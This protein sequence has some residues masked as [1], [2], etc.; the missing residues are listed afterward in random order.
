MKVMSPGMG[1][2]LQRLDVREQMVDGKFH[3]FRILELRDP[4]FWK[5][6]DLR[7]GDVVT[8]VNGQPIGHYEQAFKVWQSLAVANKIVVAYERGTEQR[9]LTLVIHEDNEDPATIGKSSAQQSPSPAANA[10]SSEAPKPPASAAPP[11][12]PKPAAK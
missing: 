2:F 4:A 7:V 11:A 9:Q 6:V 10:K 5:G 3:G 12:A 8:S 1:A